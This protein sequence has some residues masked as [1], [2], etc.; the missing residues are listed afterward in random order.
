MRHN[1]LVTLLLRAAV[2]LPAYAAAQPA[3]RSPV[4]AAGEKAVAPAPPGDSARTG[5]TPHADSS[6][7]SANDR[8]ADSVAMDDVADDEDS[9]SAEALGPGSGMVLIGHDGRELSPGRGSAGAA[10]PRMPLQMLSASSG[11]AERQWA[12]VTM[13]PPPRTVLPSP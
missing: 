12:P 9:I 13:I 11:S 2:A 8:L 10:L 6:S 1:Q 7:D 3:F 4:S 5:V